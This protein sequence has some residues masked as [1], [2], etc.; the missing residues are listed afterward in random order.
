MII[1]KIV[2]YFLLIYLGV[3]LIYLCIYLRVEE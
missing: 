2:L 1:I 3:V